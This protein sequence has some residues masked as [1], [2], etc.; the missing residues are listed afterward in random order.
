MDVYSNASLIQDD[1]VFGFSSNFRHPGPVGA[2]SNRTGT[3]KENQISLKS[4]NLTK[5]KKPCSLINHFGCVA[6]S[7]FTSQNR[8]S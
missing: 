3:E 6:R 5:T 7:I 4:D 1:L 8:V 2:V